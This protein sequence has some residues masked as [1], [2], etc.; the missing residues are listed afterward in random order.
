MFRSRFFW[1]LFLS[2]ALVILATVGSV[3]FLVLREYRQDVSERVEESLRF[4]LVAL[5]DLVDGSRPG[6]TGEQIQ[7]QVDQVSA[8]TGQRI[9]VVAA[10][11]TV[12][13]DSD[14]TPSLMENHGNL[15]LIHI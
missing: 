5:A 2:Y 1:K 12:I 3:G 9:T 6:L 15:S 10:D 13:A 7:T 4:Q 11:G 14:A 8:G